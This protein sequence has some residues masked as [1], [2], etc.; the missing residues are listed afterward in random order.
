MAA[1]VSAVLQQVAM[2]VY[3]WGR[4][5]RRTLGVVAFESCSHCQAMREFHLVQRRT[6]FTLFW[7]PVIPYKSE[8]LVL[9]GTC[10]WG[11]QPNASQLPA[12]KESIAARVTAPRASSAIAPRSESQWQ[13]GDLAKPRP[14]SSLR[15]DPLVANDTKAVDTAG[16]VVVLAVRGTWTQVRDSAGRIGWVDATQLE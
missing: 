5:T 12:L 7:I 11:W 2:I 4:Q 10:E 1:A 3:G 8:H 16:P 6:W 15:A 14:G 13:P 9:C